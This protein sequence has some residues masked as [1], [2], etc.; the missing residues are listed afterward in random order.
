MNCGWDEDK[1]NPPKEMIAHKE[2]FSCGNPTGI[3]IKTYEAYCPECGNELEI[4]S[5]DI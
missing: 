1:D 5:V 2:L 4:I 3:F